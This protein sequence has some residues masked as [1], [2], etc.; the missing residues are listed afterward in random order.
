MS[1]C[2]RQIIMLFELHVVL[3]FPL[4]RPRSVTRT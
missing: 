2:L 4:N 1:T 3:R